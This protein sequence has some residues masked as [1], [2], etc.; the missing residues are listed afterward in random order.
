MTMPAKK[1]QKATEKQRAAGRKNL[2]AGRKTRDEKRREARES[3]E[4]V[5]AKER[6][7]ALLSGTITVKDLD[8]EEIARMQVRSRDGSFGGRRR[9]VPSHLAQQ[10]QREG[11]RRATEL[12]RISAPAAVDGLLKIAEDP[13]AKD[14]D[15]IKAYSIIMDRGLGRV[16]ETVRI[17]QGELPAWDA[18]AARV[19]GL[20]AG[21]DRSGM[22]TGATGSASDGDVE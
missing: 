12:F 17:E 8:N 5:P 21:V 13:D 3:G 1:G 14:S 9:A 18:D 22:A 10:M 19:Y 15:R 7:A 2:A 4:F 11:I 16:P 6:W 20:D